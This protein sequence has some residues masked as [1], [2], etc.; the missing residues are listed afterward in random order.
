MPSQYGYR[1]GS[2]LPFPQI[3]FFNISELTCFL[4]KHS[5]VVPRCILHQISYYLGIAINSRK[6][7]WSGFTMPS[8][9]V[10]FF[11][12]YVNCHALLVN[13]EQ[14]LPVAFTRD[15]F[16]LSSRYWH[17]FLEKIVACFHDAFSTASLLSRNYDVFLGKIV[18]WVS[19]SFYEFLNP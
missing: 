6:I 12:L 4:G 13:I 8:P 3:L 9:Q 10:P 11:I 1:T 18:E 17:V 15:S 5:G 14:W 16:S 19:V 2:H 7:Y